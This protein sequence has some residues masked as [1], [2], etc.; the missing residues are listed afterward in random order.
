MSTMTT[1]LGF[2]Q[3]YGIRNFGGENIAFVDNHQVVYIGGHT[4]V[5]YNKSDKRQRFIHLS[6]VQDN[7]TAFTSESGKKLCA[8]A[9]RGDRP[10]AHV[11]DLRTCRKKKSLCAQDVNSKEFVS[12]KFSEDSAL[13]LTLTGAP[14]WTLLC[15]NWSRNKMV[16]SLQVSNS[17]VSRCTF[18]PIDASIACVTGGESVKFF[19]IAERDMR[20]LKENEY[21]NTK[22]TCHC[23]LRE[24]EDHCVAATEAGQLILFKSSEYVCHVDVSPGREFPITS[25][26]SYAE[27][28]IVGTTNGT[29]QFYQIDPA[30]SYGP[31]FTGMFTMTKTISTELTSG[32]VTSMTMN[33]DQDLLTFVSSDSQMIC[34]PMIAVNSLTDDDCYMLQCSFHGPAPITGMDVCI[35]KPLMVSCSKD[36]SLRVWNYQTN[37]VELLKHYLEDMYSVAIHPTG[38]QLALGF[39]DKI[40]IYHI[41][42]D[43]LRPCLEISIKACRE[44]RFSP[45]GNMLAA[46]NGNTVQIFDFHTGEKIADL[47]GHNGK[48]RSISWD[49]TNFRL[50]SSGQDGAIY[51][52]NLEGKRL[53]D[54]VQKGVMYTDAI[55]CDTGV[56]AVGSDSKLTELEPVELQKTQERN[57]DVLLTHLRLASTRGLLLAGTGQFNKP[58]IIRAYQY[59]LNGECVE[60][61]ALATE[62]AMMRLTFDELFLI[63]ADNLGTITIFELRDRQKQFSRN[64]AQLQPLM[65]SPNW[66]DETLVTRSELD[67]KTSSISELRTKVDELRVHIEYQLKLKD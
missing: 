14:D 10:L 57:A 11:F 20:P 24:P 21:T 1:N 45:L 64:P 7:I 15:W 8:V 18:S 63:V 62:T 2:R 30:K 39:A 47:R 27:G 4:I 9:E 32:S 25:L 28:I 29:L 61:Y 52:W 5:M 41:L 3:I 17:P 33:P 60:W 51:R 46:V 67:D 49:D 26:I 65:T 12:M 59:P 23:W 16:A 35:R 55:S 58:A 56:F 42:V 53:A 13:L 48:V 34:V 43:D 44:C 36:N 54:Y 22:I 38:L 66:T 6:E 37:E 40:R 19:R 31:D 50:L